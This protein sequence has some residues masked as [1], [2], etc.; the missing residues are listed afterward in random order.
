M[1]LGFTGYL[2]I[3]LI[4]GCAYDKRARLSLSAPAQSRVSS[5]TVSNCRS[6]QGRTGVRHPVRAYAV[7]RQPWPWL[8][9]RARV[10]RVVRHCCTRDVLRVLG[11]DWQGRRV[12][13][14]QTFTPIRDNLGPRWTFVRQVPRSSRLTEAQPAEELRLSTDCRGSLRRRWRP[15]HLLLRAQRVRRS[16]FLSSLPHR[17]PTLTIRLRSLNGDLADEDV[18]FAAFLKSRGWDGTMGVQGKEALIDR[19]EVAGSSEGKAEE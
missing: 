2:V 16:L 9:A 5:L 7:V 12:V 11:G 8:G 18:K 4:V 17:L 3:G 19:E 6:A 13:G 14:T 1:C 10:C 15:R